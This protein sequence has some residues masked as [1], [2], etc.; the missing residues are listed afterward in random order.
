MQY[1]SAVCEI[2]GEVGRRGSFLIGRILFGRTQLRY[3]RYEQANNLVASGSG[4][5]EDADGLLLPPPREWRS[6]Y[7][8]F[9]VAESVGAGI[10]TLS[11]R[12]VGDSDSSCTFSSAVGLG[13]VLHHPRSIR[14]SHERNALSG[15]AIY[16]TEH[17]LGDCAKDV[18]TGNGGVRGYRASG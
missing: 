17:V 4:R 14:R 7:D 11:A 6:G 5:D 15:A 9:L 13:W 10:L 1:H 8:S 16:E 12:S 18:W 2:K 3:H